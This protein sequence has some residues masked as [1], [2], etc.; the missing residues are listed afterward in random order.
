M[1]QDEEPINSQLAQLEYA[2]AEEQETFDRSIVERLGGRPEIQAAHLRPVTS[3]G[4]DSVRNALALSCTVHG[5]FDGRL[6]P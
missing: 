4:P 5:M 1:E 2:L 3:V 6:F